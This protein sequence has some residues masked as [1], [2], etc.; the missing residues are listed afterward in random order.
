MRLHPR[1]KVTN[2]HEIGATDEIATSAL[3]VVD[4]EHGVAARCD[5]TH[6]GLEDRTQNRMDGQNTVL[7]A[8]RTRCIMELA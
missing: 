2:I 8:A 1:M 7:T 4:S 3:A 5:R 6:P